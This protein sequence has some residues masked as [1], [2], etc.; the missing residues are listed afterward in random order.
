[1]NINFL[2]LF[3][4][5]LVSNAICQ[6]AELHIHNESDRTM[7]VKI[8]RSL[9]DGRSS[10]FGKMYINPRSNSTK[11]FSSTGYYYLKV[12]AIRL[13]RPDVFSKGDPFR[14]YVGSDGYDVLT[15]SYSIE[16]STLDPMSGETISQ[17]EF[18][19]DN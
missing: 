7:D 3:L 8:M 4:L 5:T 14:I 18:E 15:I 19:K 2:F 1:M 10:L 9:A 11:Y 16:E 17:A 6:D 12:K 13:N